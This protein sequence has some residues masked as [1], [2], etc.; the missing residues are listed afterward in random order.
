MIDKSCDELLRLSAEN[1]DL[2][3]LARRHGMSY[4]LFRREF[5]A[6]TGFSPHAYIIAFRLNR[7][8]SLLRKSDLS[9]REIAQETGFSSLAYFSAVFQRHEGISPRGWRSKNG[10]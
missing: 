5:K 6:Q 7:A 8:K 9:I 3:D 1:V 10:L 4:P 2:E